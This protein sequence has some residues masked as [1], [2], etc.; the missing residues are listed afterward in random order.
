[1]GSVAATASP[2]TATPAKPAGRTMLGI[3]LKRRIVGVVNALGRGLFIRVSFRGTRA[4]T[5]GKEIVLPAIRDLAEIPYETARALIGYAIHEVAHIRYTDFAQVARAH[6]AGKLVKKFQNCVEDYRIEREMSRAFPGAGPDL[7]ALRVRI[8]PKLSSLT[9]GWLADPRACGPLA[10][11]WTGAHLNGFANPHVQ[12]TLDAMPAPVVALI[13]DW[14]RRM[15][16]VAT[17]EEATDLAIA[18][19]EEA[20][21]YAELSRSDP[22][23]DQQDDQEDDRQDDGATGL[24]G[25]QDGAGSPGTPSGPADGASAPQGGS[26]G[27]GGSPDKGGTPSGEPGQ[28]GSDAAPAPKSD[29]VGPAPAV[30]DAQG[31]GG[32]DEEGDGEGAGAAPKGP[33]EDHERTG[34]DAGADGED[35]DSAPTDAAASS[36]DGSDATDGDRDQ[37]DPSDGLGDSLLPEPE[38]S[39]DVDGQPAGS[40]PSEG[41]AAPDGDAREPREGRDGEP[42]QSGVPEGDDGDD[43][44]DAPRE[45][46]A[47][48]VEDSVD[49]AEREGGDR[50]GSGRSQ[51]DGADDRSDDPF[52]DALDP[53]AAMD[54]LLDDI[55]EAIREAGA[56]PRQAPEASEGEV[57][58]SEAVKDLDEAN[59][60]APDYDSDDPDAGGGQDE[61]PQDS[62]PGAAKHDYRDRRIVPVPEDEA[63]GARY[64]E[65]RSGASGAISTTARVV[66]RLLMA[67]EKKG[68]LRNRRT[69][70]FDIRNM[71]AIIRGTGTCYRRKWERP[72]PR[73]LLATLVDFSG[74]MLHDQSRPW[75]GP[76]SE[77]PTPLDLAMTGAL[78]IEE[79]VRGTSVDSLLYGYTGHSPFVQL[80]PFKDG[81]SSKLAVNRAIGS[82]RGCSK[83]C[84]PTGEAMAALALR[85]E[86][87]DQE[88]RVMLVL[89]DG[90]A[91]DAELCAAACQTMIRRGIEVV[92]IGIQC[93]AVA[94]WAPVHHVIHDVT[95]LPQAL[96]A[97]IDPRA[98]K[99]GQRRLAA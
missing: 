76:K 7:T 83:G 98:S 26:P 23:A 35:G 79:A 18:F 5:N 42:D 63:G 38:A 2:A 44:D 17:T 49:Q 59:A 80:Y 4:F 30:P 28:T 8:H 77:G 70:E 71:N 58:P 52:G 50:T 12:K 10:L 21:R 75:N 11:T 93:D 73:T 46:S 68:V 64:A 32:G 84:T 92:A 87:A 48:E 41:D 29:D 40:D 78:A 57:D 95:Q 39:D 90:G 9:T 82:F 33:V 96:L 69:G 89:T 88:R 20:N 31:A 3:D 51:D 25:A 85:M 62:G 47:D 43:A 22:P 15:E 34:S 6:E 37:D 13:D 60:A 97:T 36:E 1:M 53:N 27:E 94:N 66:R 99:G 19:T 14:T 54:D 45:G 86:R 74:S 24:G 67:E 56:L 91:D 16:H 65:L 61:E 81:A 72:A 55:A